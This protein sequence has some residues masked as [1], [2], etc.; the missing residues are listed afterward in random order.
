M[1]SCYLCE[2]NSRYS[3]FA[4]FCERCQRIKRMINL[5]GLE[6]VV[7][8]LD[9]VLVRNQTQQNHKI[10]IVIDE[11]SNNIQETQRVLRSHKKLDTIK[12]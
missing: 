5:Y 4:Y 3:H 10:K 7:D 2:E 12:E 11:E 1:G 6:R 8:I 9:F